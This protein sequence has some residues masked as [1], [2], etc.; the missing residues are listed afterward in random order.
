MKPILIVFSNINLVR[1]G[2]SSL[3]MSHWRMSRPSAGVFE[4]TT[5]TICSGR[6]QNL[7][8]KN[9]FV[10]HAILFLA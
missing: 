1:L 7:K 6:N 3:Q 8:K 4:M 2:A 5:T 9:D 10:G